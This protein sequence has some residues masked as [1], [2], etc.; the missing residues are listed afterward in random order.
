MFQQDHH[1]F[2]NSIRG[3][4]FELLEASIL[5]SSFP[6]SCDMTEKPTNNK[7]KM[8]KW[9]QSKKNYQRLMSP[10]SSVKSY[11]FFVLGVFFG[12]RVL[13]VSIYYQSRND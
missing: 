4:R 7:K 11:I 12:I 8:K 1:P 13:Q 10:Q 3:D 9:N 5:I 6:S 2:L